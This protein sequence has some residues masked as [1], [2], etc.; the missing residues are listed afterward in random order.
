MIQYREGC[1]KQNKHGKIK[2]GK[3]EERG[4]KE[5]KERII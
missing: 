4:K 1:Q 2:K 3:K 5:R